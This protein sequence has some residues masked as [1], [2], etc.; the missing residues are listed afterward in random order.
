MI[1]AI[2]NI[3]IGFKLRPSSVHE[4]MREFKLEW[5]SEVAQVLVINLGCWSILAQSDP[6][7]KAGQ[8]HIRKLIEVP[9]L[10]KIPNNSLI[11]FDLQY[12]ENQYR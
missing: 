2:E 10:T 5:N 3:N 4:L 6:A 12:L 7:H 8:G 9:L 1:T 11:S